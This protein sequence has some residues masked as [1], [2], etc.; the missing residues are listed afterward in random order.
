MTGPVAVERNLLIAMPDG[1]ELAA[2]LYRP[3][4]AGRAPAILT[5]IPYHKDGRGGRLDVEA[6]NRHFAARGYAAVTADLRGLGGSG[7]VN[8]APFD[9]QEAR[10]GHAVVEWIA[11]QPWCD[12]QVGMWGVS[13]GGITALAVAATRPPHLRAIVSVHACADIYHDFL[14]PGG[15]RGGFWSQADWGPRMVAYNLAPPLWQDEDGRWARVWAERLEANGP[16]MLAWWDHPEFDDFWRARVIPVDRIAVPAFLIGGWRDLYAE[17]TVRDFARLSGPRRLLVG[18]WKH[19]F[20]DV[21][22]EAPAPGLREMERWWERW[23]RGQP[24]GVDAEPP[25]TVHVQGA[26]PGWRQEP[27][28]PPPGTTPVT[29][30]LRSG[31]GLAPEGPEGDQAETYVADPAVGLGSIAWDAWTTTLDPALP[32]DQSADDARSLA[33]TSAPLGAPLELAGSPSAGLEITASTETTLVVRL[34]DVAPNGR[35]TLVTLG[36]TRVGPEAA[37]SRTPVAVALRATAYRFP[38]GHRLRLAVACADFPRVWPA[39]RRARI[40]L[41]AGRSRVVL[42]VAPPPAAPGP[43]WGEPAPASLRSAADLGGGQHWETRHDLG[44]DLV[45][46][47]GAKEEHLQLDALTRYHA[48]HRYQASVASGRP[49]LARMSSATE[50]AVERPVGHTELSVTTVTTTQAVSITATITIDRSP[51]W[52]RTWTRLR[53]AS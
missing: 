27:G 34:A 23:L 14:A 22:L 36:W 1:V 2:D 40:A 32:R 37:G 25:V 6:V 53:P 15:C 45:T 42:P 31:G 51:F 4:G 35:S 39:P 17:A 30:Y 16:W 3:P 21:A 52:S 12:G 50:I 47:D 24:N 49:D 11:R 44:H 26:G 5:F 41:H 43:A 13:Y 48:R 7:G 28:W 9:P 20:P 8:P 33:F 10:D 18:P 29:W 38:A 46:L 19:A